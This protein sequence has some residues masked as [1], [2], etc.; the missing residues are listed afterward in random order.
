MKINAETAGVILRKKI[1]TAETAEQHGERANLSH[2]KLDQQQYYMVLQ[3]SGENTN[4]Y[5]ADIYGK[6]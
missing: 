2:I 6:Q 5:P 3:P 1:N 4:V